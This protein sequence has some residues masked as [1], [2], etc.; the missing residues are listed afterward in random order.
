MN[1]RASPETAAV[2]R[3]AM[4]AAGLSTVVEPEEN[5]SGATK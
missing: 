4:S 3:K 1:L 5:I 2:L